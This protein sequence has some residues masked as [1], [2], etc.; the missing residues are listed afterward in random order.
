MCIAGQC[1]CSTGMAACGSSGCADLLHDPLNCGTCGH[2]CPGKHACANGVCVCAVPDDNADGHCCPFSFDLQ[3]SADGKGPFCYSNS[4]VGAA[5]LDLAETICSGK[6]ACV[7]FGAVF[8]NGAPASIPLDAG[9]GSYHDGRAGVGNMSHDQP[10]VGTYQLG[11][12][13][14]HLT[15]EATCSNTCGSSPANPCSCD[16]GDCA[17]SAAASGCAQSFYCVSDPLGPRQATCSSATDCPGGTY[18][19]GGSCL[20]SSDFGCCVSAYHCGSNNPAAF[21]HRLGAH[22]TGYCQ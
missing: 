14:L 5:T 9:C 22:A 8:F 3:Y 16:L 11:G 4:F 6:S 20:S 17:C 1:A 19:D 10:W 18:C 21:C 13:A 15:G 12:G 2:E 7:G